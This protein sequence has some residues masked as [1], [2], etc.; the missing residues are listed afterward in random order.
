MAE[1]QEQKTEGNGKIPIWQWI[2]IFLVIVGIGF[3]GIYYFLRPGQS[4]TQ[5]TEQQKASPT[6]AKITKP[7]QQ[8]QEVITLT[9]EGFSPETLTIKSGTTV[10]W[11]NKSR[12]T[13]SIDSDPHP[14]HT[15]YPPLNLGRLQANRTF[16]LTFD[17]PGT[18]GYHNHLDPTKRG[19]IIV[20]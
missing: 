2:V 3:V 16:L 9:N 8:I 4:Q 20:E 17:K 14:T 15:A 6:A 1:L 12:R 10:S 18:Y 7:L 5:S 19:T 11:I 13:A